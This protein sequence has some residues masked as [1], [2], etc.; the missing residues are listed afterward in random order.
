[1]TEH[2]CSSFC[3]GFC[4]MDYDPEDEDTMPSSMDD[5]ELCIDDGENHGCTEFYWENP[6]DPYDYEQNQ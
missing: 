4:G 3:N 2:I 5:M 6:D 1:M